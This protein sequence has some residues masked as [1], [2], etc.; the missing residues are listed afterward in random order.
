[1]GLVF[2]VGPF[3]SV[4]RRGGCAINKEVAFLSGA[5]GVVSNTSR[6]AAPYR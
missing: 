6:E 2:E 1:M 4:S 5:D 3:P